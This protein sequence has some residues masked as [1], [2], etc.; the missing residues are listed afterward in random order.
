[1]IETDDANDPCVLCV[2]W[3]FPDDVPE[4]DRWDGSL[5]VPYNPDGSPVDRL[6]RGVHDECQASV[7][8]YIAEQSGGQP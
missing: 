2:G 3:R 4:E 1:M 7:D 5:E 6:Y 8:A